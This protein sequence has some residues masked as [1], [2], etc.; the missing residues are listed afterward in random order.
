MSKVLAILVVILFAVVGVS[1]QSESNRK[2]DVAEKPV[3]AKYVISVSSKPGVVE[4]G[5]RTTYLKEGLSAEEVL[6]VMGT[7]AAVSERDEQGSIVK[8]YEF[9]R[10]DGR[11]L[12]AEFI[13]NKLVRSRTEAS[14]QSASLESLGN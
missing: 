1:A 2:P 3:K 10:G 7:P 5:P 6:R 8:S 4:L 12:I 14:G 9:K 13:D 11:V